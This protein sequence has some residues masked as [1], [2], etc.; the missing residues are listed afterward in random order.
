[1]CEKQALAE[2][3]PMALKL[4]KQLTYRNEFEDLYQL[5]K[6]AIIEAIRTFDP[7]RG[8]KLST[9]VFVMILSSLRKFDSKNNS[10]I[11]QPHYVKNKLKRVDFDNINNIISTVQNIENSEIKLVLEMCLNN[12]T[13][14]QKE[15]L[16]MRYF[17]GYSISEIAKL[18]NCSHQNI[19]KINN[20][21]LTEVQK[22]LNG[23][24]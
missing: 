19:S 3:D 9:H 22:V 24:D 18:L 16:Q 13:S 17:D 14:K 8:V 11:Y 20:K 21:A 7:A 5:A 10:I 2:F 15:I 23:K 6:I 4:S 12:L 1:M